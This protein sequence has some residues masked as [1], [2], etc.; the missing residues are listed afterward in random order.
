MSCPDM[1]NP[2]LVHQRKEW[3]KKRTHEVMR[4]G[5]EVEG[6]ESDLFECRNCGSSRTRYRRWRR[7]AV[8][9]PDLSKTRPESSLGNKCNMRGAAVRVPHIVLQ[10]IWQ[11]AGQH[12][13]NEQLRRQ[14]GLRRLFQHQALYDTR[15]RLWRDEAKA[16]VL[17]RRI[18]GSR[19]HRSSSVASLSFS[20]MVTRG[21][22]TNWLARRWWN[23]ALALASADFSPLDLRRSLHFS[24]LTLLVLSF[25]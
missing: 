14:G 21:P 9:D 6:F 12:H 5:R 24:A 19:S 15:V 17:S 16:A 13:R 20:S 4:D 2:Q 22:V 8:V 25:I 18:Y 7:K 3:I 10:Q 1:A 23:W 11:I